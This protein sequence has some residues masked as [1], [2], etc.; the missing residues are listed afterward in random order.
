MVP[1]KK[2]NRNVCMGLVARSGIAISSFRISSV[3]KTITRSFDS[4]LCL[5]I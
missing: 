1:A 5:I 2:I 4:I 3:L